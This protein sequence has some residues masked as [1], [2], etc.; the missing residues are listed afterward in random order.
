MTRSRQYQHTEIRIGVTPDDPPEAKPTATVSI[1]ISPQRDYA[2]HLSAQ[3]KSADGV[4]TIDTLLK[5]FPDES[6]LTTLQIVSDLTPLVETSGPQAEDIKMQLLSL[7][8]D[9]LQEYHSIGPN[10]VYNY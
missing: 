3:L 6:T 4:A 10:S 8:A 9:A 2:T 1:H 7:T 5:S